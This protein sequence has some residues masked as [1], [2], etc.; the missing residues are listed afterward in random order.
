IAR[1]VQEDFKEMLLGPRVLRT[2]TAALTAITALQC[3]F[4]DLA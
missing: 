1:T 4:G 3:R 2:E